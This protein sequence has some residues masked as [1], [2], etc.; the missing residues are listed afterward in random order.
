MSVERN[1]VDISKLFRWGNKFNII[2]R[3]GE[4][5]TEVYIRLV[6]DAELNR[7]RVMAIRGS[8]ELRKKLKE[9][10]TDERLAF[11]PEFAD[12][13]REMAEQTLLLL[14]TRIFGQQATRE[15]DLPYP[16]EPKSD[17]SLEDQEKYQAEVDSFPERREQKV[18]EFIIKKL[19]EKE[20]ELKTKSDEFI[21]REYERILINDLCEQEMIR[22][23]RDHNIYLGSY[24]D[25]NFKQKLFGS[26]DEFV[27]LP[28]EIKQQFI[29]YYQ[30]LEI[31]VDFL[32][33][34]QGATQ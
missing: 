14:Y 16:V 23:F 21:A 7:S 18:K 12:I 30:S 11:I 9:K 4:V 22:L 10:D 25:Q 15:V 1:D 17:A 29:D 13:G 33:G 8:A 34:S 19:L 32:K 20:D 24:S 28:T 27:N 5:V 31:S 2:G 6:G 3:N 26:F